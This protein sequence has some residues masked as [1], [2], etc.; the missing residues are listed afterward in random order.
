MKP[1]SRLTKSPR[2]QATL[3]LLL[4]LTLGVGTYLYLVSFQAK[5]EAKNRLTPVLVAKSEIPAGMSFEEIVS[6]SLF[7]VKELPTDSLPAEALAPESQLDDSL[8]TKGPLVAGQILISSYFSPEARRTVGLAIP[9][10]MLAVT[11]SVDDVSRVG[12]FVLPGSRVAIFST[13]TSSSGNP[14]TEV[15]MNEA[16]VI[17]I[18]DQTDIALET[19]TPIPSPLVTLALAPQDAKRVISASRSTQITLALAHENDPYAV[20]KGSTG[21]NPTSPTT[22]G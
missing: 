4:S 5:V 11:I 8:K 17:G 14:T 15:L 1:K 12:N 10:G 2:F 16:L 6:S 20:I 22:G 7:E 19:T 9:R 18:G 21:S 13:T 3:V